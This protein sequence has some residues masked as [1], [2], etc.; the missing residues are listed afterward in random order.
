MGDPLLEFSIYSKNF[1]RKDFENEVRTNDKI[2]WVR[3]HNDIHAGRFIRYENCSY[4]LNCHCK[5]KIRIQVLEG[6]L[7]NKLFSL[8]A[9]HK[10]KTQFR[11]QRP[12][13]LPDE[14]FEI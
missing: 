9:T 10:G 14:L 3:E 11:W 12:N 6:N 2:E 4:Q 7:K 13:K 5:G 1:L 8:C